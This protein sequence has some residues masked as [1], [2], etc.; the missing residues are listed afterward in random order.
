MIYAFH[1][2]S[3]CHEIVILLINGQKIVLLQLTDNSSKSPSPAY[4]HSQVGIKRNT[5][6]SE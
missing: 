5:F 3:S 6:S 4:F 2:N 1:L